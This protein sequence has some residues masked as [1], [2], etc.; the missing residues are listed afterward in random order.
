MKIEKVAHLDLPVEGAGGQDAPETRGPL[1]VESLLLVGRGG[2][3]ATEDVRLLL[4]LLL[5]MLAILLLLRRSARVG[6]V[7]DRLERVEIPDDSP[8]VLA[9]GDEETVIKGAPVD[10]EDPRVVPL[11][12]RER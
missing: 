6:N 8:V 12:S 1:D 11:E 7:V 10:R 2:T 4:L 5:L 9:G 3:D